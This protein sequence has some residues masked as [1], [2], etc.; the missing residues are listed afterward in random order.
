MRTIAVWVVVALGILTH[1]NAEEDVQQDS[2]FHR[3]VVVTASRLADDTLAQIPASV[4]VFSEREIRNTPARHVDDVL[5][6]A[7]GIYVLRSTGMGYGLPVQ[8]A[9]RAVPGQST[10]LLLSD[11]LPLNEAVSGFAD[12]NAIPLEGVR[13][14]EFVRGPQSSLYGANAF[15]GVVNVLTLPPD[16]RPAL[17]LFHRSGNEGFREWGASASQGD[18]GLGVSVDL[19]TREIDNYLA[20]DAVFTEQWSS[21]AQRYYRSSRPA[22]NYAYED[23]RLVGKLTADL[24]PETHL[25]VHVRYSDGTLGYGQ[26]DVRPLYPTLGDSTMDVESALL[27]AVLTSVLSDDVDFKGRAYYREQ[28]RALHGLNV[29]HVQSGIPVFVPSE[30]ET[31]VR[32]WMGDGAFDIRAFEGHAITIG[33]DFQRT[34]ADFSSLRNA[35]TQQR[36][37]VSSGRE[38]HS[39]NAGLYLQDRIAL[40]ERATALC[41]LRV[42]EHDAYG[43]AVSPKAGVVVQVQDSMRVHA[44]AGR[45]YRAPSLIEL[46]QPSIFFGSVTFESNSEL[47]PEYISTVDGGVE[48]MVTESLMVRAD[49]FYNDMEDLITKQISGSTLRYANTDEA[50]SAGAE[51]GLE[52][53][54]LPACSLGLSYT[55]Q[56]GENRDTGADLEHIP[57][58]L[59][60]LSVR[61]GETFCDVWLVEAS[62]SENYVGVRGYVDLSS[63]LW[64]ELGDYWRT[65][66][67]LKLTYRDRVWIGANVQNASDEQYQEWPQ[68]N[69][70]PGRLY[71]FEVGAR[72]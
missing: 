27:G 70:A 42:D 14:I 47:K 25:D 16:Q 28:E 62:L 7:P 11:G 71:A 66:V 39:V 38:V 36:L 30:S 59:A 60:S 29:S 24:S 45:A 6:M 40:Q 53:G 3:D 12:V 31:G 50:W 19:S 63:G 48:C 61:A 49:L 72:W 22:E 57:E 44:S 46:Y 8:L 69:P 56:Q 2:L 55:E 15:A 35:A 20:Q 1:V 5:R 4:T 10:T 26:T 43:S 34:D 17:S 65:D 58:R 33:A 54:F 23:R 32:D 67:S 41:G 52:W 64:R 21:A 18:Y 68:V 13:R 9:A 51:L 37:P